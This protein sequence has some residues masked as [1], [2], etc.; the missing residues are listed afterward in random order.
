MVNVTTQM[1]YILIRHG[2]LDIFQYFMVHDV[3]GFC[4]QSKEL[5]RPGHMSG[6]YGVPGATSRRG[7]WGGTPRQ[8]SY[9]DGEKTY[10]HVKGHATGTDL[11]E[12][13]TIFC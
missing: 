5:F 6:G 7:F 3:A 12:L 8:T 4:G 9:Q 1:A 10:R 2:N 11:L 13:P